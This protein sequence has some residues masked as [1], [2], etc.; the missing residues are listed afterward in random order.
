[1]HTTY[2]DREKDRHFESL[3]FLPK[4][5]WK[6]TNFV[7]STLNEK[8]KAHRIHIL[9]FLRPIAKMADE[10]KGSSKVENT[11]SQVLCQVMAL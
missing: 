9:G 3:F 8:P 4:S 1:M 5:I 6:R 7:H 10:E 2:E 11:S